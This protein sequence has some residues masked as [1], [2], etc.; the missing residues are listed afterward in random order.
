MA[1]DMVKWVMVSSQGFT[2]L[3]IVQENYV[4][5]KFTV[6][7]IAEDGN[8]QS[9]TFNSQRGTLSKPP[10]QH[11]LPPLSAANETESQFRIRLS[12]TQC[13]SWWMRHQYKVK[14]I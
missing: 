7:Q 9:S 1:C 13:S 14:V 12:I 3:E 8:G 4:N 10:R 11:K 6:Q 2:I 5:K